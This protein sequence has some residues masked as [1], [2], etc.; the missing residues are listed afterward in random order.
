VFHRHILPGN[1]CAKLRGGPNWRWLQP[2]PFNMHIILI[3][4]LPVPSLHRSRLPPSALLLLNSS[5]SS[6]MSPPAKL[7]AREMTSHGHLKFFQRPARDWTLA[8]FVRYRLES[9]LK[10]NPKSTSE[11]L[12]RT[13]TTSWMQ[14]LNKISTCKKCSPA[15]KNCATTL[16]G[17]FRKPVRIN[18]LLPFLLSR[19]W[20][21]TP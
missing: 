19:W 20:W 13:I 11:E 7:S 9:I 5:I 6:T 3:D 14:H 12:E 2:P 21:Q 4:R 15:S 10:K 1:R 18:S 16:M 17:E 8:E